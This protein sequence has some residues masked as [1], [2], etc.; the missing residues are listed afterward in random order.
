M[1]LAYHD[2]MI[3]EWVGRTP[4]GALYVIRIDNDTFYKGSKVYIAHNWRKL[5]GEVLRM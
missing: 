3:C 5:T 1:L 2:G 4:Y